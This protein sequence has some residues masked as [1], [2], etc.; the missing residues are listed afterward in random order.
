MNSLWN[1][2]IIKR[3]YCAIHM[4]A[5]IRLAHHR[6]NRNVIPRKYYHIRIFIMQSTRPTWGWW[7]RL[8]IY[9]MKIPSM[10]FIYFS[11]HDTSNISSLSNLTVNSSLAYQTKCD[12]IFSDPELDHISLYLSGTYLVYIL[13]ILVC[14][15][16]PL[17][18]RR[19]R[20]SNI[21]SIDSWLNRIDPSTYIISCQMWNGDIEPNYKYNLEEY[22]NTA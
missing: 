20:C 13:F 21:L 2:W 5:L 12:N 19:G 14:G 15:N 9:G 22:F 8:V 11:N 18:L 10:G 7:I 6:W 1:K 3:K 17:T 4:L 16:Y